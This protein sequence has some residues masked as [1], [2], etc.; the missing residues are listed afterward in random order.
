M[1]PAPLRNGL[2]ASRLQLPAG[3][4]PTVLDA[5]SALFPRVPHGDW[6]QRFER[7][8]VLD[9]EGQALALD[10]PCREGA[11][12]QY[13]REVPAET[14]IPFTETVLYADA[15]LVVADKPHFLP[16]TPAGGFV[17][18]TLLTRLISRLG[19]AD[20]VPLH[21]IDRTTAGLVLFSA[22][23]DSRAAYQALFRE[24][25][26]SKR[27]EALAAPL[28]QHR[29]PLTRSSRIVEGEPFFRMQEAAGTPNCETRIEVIEKGERLWRYALHP[30]TGKKHQLR[31]QMAA[32]GAAIH[33]DEFY[34][35]LQPRMEGDYRQP[36]QLLAQGLSFTD[37]LTG[38][39]RAFSSRLA[40]NSVQ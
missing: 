24:R 12:I 39:A 17:E 13:Y 28:P 18:H 11:L 25:R 14:P 5:L 30:V 29:F 20:L 6:Q 38:E 36:L 37:P 26:I 22:H 7:G 32:L 1:S 27:Y 3:P 8:L 40:L 10:A 34:P 35:D 15:H 16:V 2:A 23:P 4:W 21:R 31:V 33:N 9:A 19:N